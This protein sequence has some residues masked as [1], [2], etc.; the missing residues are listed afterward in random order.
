M[1]NKFLDYIADFLRD[2][3]DGSSHK[4][5][6]SFACFIVA[7]VLA[8]QNKDYMIIGMFLGGAF[9]ESVATLFEKDK[10]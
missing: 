10:I 8:F 1:V 4:R 3:N 6:L 7:V 2:R 5:L 9:G